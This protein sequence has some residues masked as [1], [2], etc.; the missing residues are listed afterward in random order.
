VSWR[1]DTNSQAV[2]HFLGVVDEVARG[3]RPTPRHAA[4]MSAFVPRVG[5]G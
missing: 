5:V 4:G 2:R 3:A 1:R